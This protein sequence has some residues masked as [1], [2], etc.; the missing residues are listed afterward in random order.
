[1]NYYIT[2]TPDK[3]FFCKDR[4]GKDLTKDTFETFSYA[5]GAYGFVIEYHERLT[6]QEWIER[7]NAIF[8]ETPRTQRVIEAIRTAMSIQNF[9]EIKNP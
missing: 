5:I 2:R 9:D 6:G 8:A 3:G 1:M 7:I 4:A